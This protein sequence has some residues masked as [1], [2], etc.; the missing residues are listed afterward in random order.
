MNHHRRLEQHSFGFITV[1]SAEAAERI[2][3]MSHTIDGRQ[4]GVP[5]VAKPIRSSDGEKANKGKSPNVSSTPVADAARIAAAYG[6]SKDLNAIRKIFVGGLS[7]QTKEQALEVR[8][9]LAPLPPHRRLT[10]LR[11]CSELL[12]V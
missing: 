7:H 12:E 10:A 1:Q 5:E 6:A 3:A 2:M 9:R 4:V 11:I 8:A